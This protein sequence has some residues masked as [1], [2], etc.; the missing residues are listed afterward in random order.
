MNFICYEF[1]K[2]NK[3]RQKFRKK[4][5][6]LYRYCNLIGQYLENFLFLLEFFISKN[7]KRRR[8]FRSKGNKRKTRVIHERAADGR[9]MAEAFEA[10]GQ[11]S[12]ETVIGVRIGCKL[13]L[14]LSTKS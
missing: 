11:G 3:K 1:R 12:T 9:W 6:I 13:V 10:V 2:I 5:K 7:E 4:E 14:K 8:P